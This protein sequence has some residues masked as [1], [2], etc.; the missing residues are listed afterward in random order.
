MENS[1]FPTHIRGVP[2]KAIGLALVVLFLLT[3]GF[4]LIKF[5]LFSAIRLIRPAMYVYGVLRT[6]G[7]IGGKARR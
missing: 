3:R 2:F 5:V 4:R 6:L 7:F 1:S